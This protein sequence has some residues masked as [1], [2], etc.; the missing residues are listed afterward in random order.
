[1]S[2]LSV[3]SG[4]G[5]NAPAGSGSSQE[6]AGFAGGFKIKAPLQGFKNDWNDANLILQDSLGLAKAVTQDLNPSNGNVT[7]N[8]SNPVHSKSDVGA[9]LLD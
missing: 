9:V 5:L 2:N 3:D 6:T 7:T 4:A 1:M 8:N